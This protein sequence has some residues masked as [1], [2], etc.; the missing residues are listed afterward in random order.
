M[1]VLL[2]CLSDFRA[3]G[4]RQ[5]VR[6]AA[7]LRD[8]GH[9]ARVMIEGDPETLRFA[10]ERQLDVDVDRFGFH[11]PRLDS[12]TRR[13]AV[14]FSPDV[15]HCYEPRTAPLS[16]SLQLARASG[17]TLCV[18]FADDDEALAREAG[19]SG[20]RGR[21]GRPVMLA[22]GTVSPPRWPFKH[23]LHYRAMFRRAAG[24]D[25]ITPALAEAVSERYGVRCEGILPAIAGD[26]PPA[27][28]AGLRSRLGLPADGPLILYTGSV[29]RAQYPDLDLLIRG[30]GILAAR[31]RDA[32]LVHTGRIAPRYRTDELRER[33]GAPG[34]THFLGFLEDPADLG[35]LIAEADVLVQPGAP[36]EFNRLRL[37]AKVHDYLLAGRPTVTFRAGFG[38]MLEDRRDAVLTHTAQ[39]QELADALDWVL[40]D[41]DRAEALARR[42]R[43]TA[44]RLFDPAAIAAQTVD[45]YRRAA[46]GAG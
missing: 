7:A 31:G 28:A 41:P 13:A 4:A 22:A 6:L 1:R 37:P 26:D 33:T 42:G 12:R 3:P 11:G 10:A 18:R 46:A 5:T 19:G 35:A 15:I 20:W 36:S 8:A 39:P 9:E 40:A 38:E 23:P 14:D 34:N 17:A 16:A 30:F 25:A 32:H 45:Y 2:V 21:L 44:R 43:E 27:R 29:Y 24:F